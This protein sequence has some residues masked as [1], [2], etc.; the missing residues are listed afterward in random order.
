MNMN[1]LQPAM[2]TSLGRCGRGRGGRGRGRGQVLLQPG[3]VVKLPR[4]THLLDQI[5]CRHVLTQL[6]VADS[7]NLRTKIR[8]GLRARGSSIHVRPFSSS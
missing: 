2:H 7:E 3:S 8:T 5:V 6:L 4:A 1:I